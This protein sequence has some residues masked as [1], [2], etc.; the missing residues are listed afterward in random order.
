LPTVLL[1][2]PA[3]VA[4]GGSFVTVWVGLWVCEP[5]CLLLPVSVA[6][7]LGCVIVLG[8]RSPPGPQVGP[9]GPVVLR[10]RP[11]TRSRASGRG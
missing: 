2:L 3:A 8:L 9:E 1:P 10:I 7:A 11:E 4:L 5:S 6:I